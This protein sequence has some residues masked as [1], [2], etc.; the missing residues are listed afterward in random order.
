MMGT[1][2]MPRC[3]SLYKQSMMGFNHTGVAHKR[4]NATQTYPITRLKR[5][6]IFSI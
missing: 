5:G 1:G 4:N 6:L 2:D 3:P